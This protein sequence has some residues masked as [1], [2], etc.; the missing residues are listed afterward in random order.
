MNKKIILWLHMHQP[1]YLESTTGN[2]ILPWVRRHS[3][4]GYYTI[5]KLLEQST[6]KANINFSGILL[7]QIQR[8]QKG[9]RD[10]YQLYEDEEPSL[11]TGSEIDFIIKRFHTPASF[12][13]ERFESIKENYK[14]TRRISEQEIL[15]LQT[16]FKLSAFAPIEKEILEL[17]KKG[18]FYSK[19]DKKVIIELEN[20]IINELFDL[21]S[22]LQKRNQIEITFTPYHHPIL[23]LL[24]DIKVAK[25]SKHNAIIADMETHFYEDAD[26]HTKE[27]IKKIEEIFGITPT[28]CWPAEGGISKETIQFLKNSGVL[29]LGSDEALVKPLGLGQGV[30]EYNGVKLF[31]RNHEV[32]DKIGF[33]YNKMNPKDAITDLK[34][35]V[36][37]NGMLILI[38]DGEN[39]WEYFN[40]Y[41]VD[42]LKNLF[43]TFNEKDSLLGNEVDTPTHIDKIHPGS[44]ID[45]YFDTWIGDEETDTAWTQLIEARSKINTTESFNEIYKSEASDY[46]WWY[47]D[48]HKQDINFDFDTL[49]RSRLIK[50]YQTS[51]LQVPQYLYYPIKKFPLGG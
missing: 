34:N 25:E 41:G 13:S 35:E 21:Y 37:K 15:D 32:S 9:Q 3:L 36:D 50:A 4:N 42:F 6:F 49:F 47:S 38:L 39:P 10:V 23:P 33:V 22:L 5:A 14:S 27:S 17:R 45:G 46:F 43:N 7:E 26:F 51:N 44:W 24:L 2:I 18:K 1:D 12:R 28:G 48:F 40:N 8:Y 20:K 29:W 30:Y 16:I 11:L 19:D 31:L